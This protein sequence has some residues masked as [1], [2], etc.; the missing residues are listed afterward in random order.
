[1]QNVISQDDDLIGFYGDLVKYLKDE[2]LG[3]LQEEKGAPDSGA[4]AN[5]SEIFSE[6]E[7]QKDAPGLL[8]ISENN[9]MGWT[10]RPY[11]EN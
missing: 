9:G 10:V 1:M 11:N 3:L 2:L 7:G 5:Y 8:V 6:L 4:L